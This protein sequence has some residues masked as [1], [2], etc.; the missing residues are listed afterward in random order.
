MFQQ[1]SPTTAIDTRFVPEYLASPQC[2]LSVLMRCCRWQDYAS[3]RQ[4]IHPQNE[5][6]ESAYSSSQ[7]K[8]TCF[9]TTAPPRCR[10]RG[11][12]NHSGVKRLRTNTP[13]TKKS[14]TY[15]HIIQPAEQITAP[16]KSERLHCGCPDRR[17]DGRACIHASTKSAGGQ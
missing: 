3:L 2:Q 15:D 4:G 6:H 14:K 11:T 10:N 8:L 9:V 5:A 13:R 17:G 1:L 7:I 12:V 16:D